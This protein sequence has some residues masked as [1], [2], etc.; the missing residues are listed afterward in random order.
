MGNV[1]N[2]CEN[3]KCGIEWGAGVGNWNPETG[4]YDLLS[5]FSWSTVVDNW[6]EGNTRGEQDLNSSS[7]PDLDVPNSAHG[8]FNE[9]L[10][11]FTTS[12][13]SKTFDQK[14]SKNDVRHSASNPD[15]LSGTL[16]TFPCWKVDQEVGAEHAEYKVTVKS[17]SFSDVGWSIESI[18]VEV[19]W[20]P[21]IW[22]LNS[23]NFTWGIC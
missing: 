1:T 8:W 6:P 11:S 10:K 12:F 16:D 18:L 20:V 19:I 21:D 2:E 15:H 5:S 23:S 9:I 22:G 14:D 17:T 13:K 3:S 7:L 4:G